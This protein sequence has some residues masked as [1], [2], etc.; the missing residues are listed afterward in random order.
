M[1]VENDRKMNS[2]TLCQTL[3]TRQQ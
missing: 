3:Y 2:I 1:A